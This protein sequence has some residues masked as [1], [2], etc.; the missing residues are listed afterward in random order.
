[1][2]NVCLPPPVTGG[3]DNRKESNKEQVIL[4][5]SLPTPVLIVIAV[6]RICCSIA[7]IPQPEMWSISFRFLM[8]SD[9]PLVFPAG[10]R[11]QNSWAW[12]QLPSG[13]GSASSTGEGSRWDF[14]RT[15]LVPSYIHPDVLHRE[16][17]VC[18]CD[19]AAP[20]T[21]RCFSTNEGGVVPSPLLT[22]PEVVG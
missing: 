1:M 16:L 13:K 6:V 5:S 15:A 2:K 22:P 12:P 20:H 21:L 14:S 9:S 4:L 19:P 18:A 11:G 10:A 17:S 7:P 3:G 8:M